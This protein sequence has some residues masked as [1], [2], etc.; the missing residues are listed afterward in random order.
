MQ[1]IAK[2]L[3]LFLGNSMTKYIEKLEEIKKSE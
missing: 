2:I 3:L 1:S